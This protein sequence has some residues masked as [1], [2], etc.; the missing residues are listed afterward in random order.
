MHSRAHAQTNDLEE[1]GGGQRAKAKRVQPFDGASAASAAIGALEAHETVGTAWP[2]AS[3]AVSLS[4]LTKKAQPPT[5]ARR[6]RARSLR[7][8]KGPQTM[9]R[10]T[11]AGGGSGFAH[12]RRR[13]PGLRSLFPAGADLVSAVLP[14]LTEKTTFK[15]LGF[16]VCG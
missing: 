1:R 15:R 4:T 12:V 5:V 3:A 13:P 6:A 14:S 10:E 9:G 7:T 2:P 8:Q 16:A 11:P